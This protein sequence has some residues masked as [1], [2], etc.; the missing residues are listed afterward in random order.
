MEDD[1]Q[2]VEGSNRIGKTVSEEDE[3]DAWLFSSLYVALPDHYLNRSD[4]DDS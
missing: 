4:D 2:M 3:E 1:V